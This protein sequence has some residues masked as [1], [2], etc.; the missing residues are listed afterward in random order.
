MPSAV[1]AVSTHEVVLGYART[2]PSSS[3]G[4]A[5]MGVKRT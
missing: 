4:K 1:E 5:E 2:S 3:L